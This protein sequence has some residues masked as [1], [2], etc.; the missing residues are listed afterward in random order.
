MNCGTCK[1]FDLKNSP[2][3][4]VGFGLC[5]AETNPMMRAGRT[6]NPQN[7]CRLGKFEKAD[8]R[9]IVKREKELGVIL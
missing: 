4:S 7:I 6:L 2:T 1:H 9:A 5:Q 8:P 3:R